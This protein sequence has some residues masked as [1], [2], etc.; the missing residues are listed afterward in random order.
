MRD[1]SSDPGGHTGVARSGQRL[2]PLAARLQERAAR[3]RPRRRVDQ[4][5]TVVEGRREVA[6]ARAVN[7]ISE[8][9]TEQ[10]EL[11]LWLT[12]AESGDLLWMSPA[13]TRLFGV[14]VESFYDDPAK[15]LDLVYPDD[16]HLLVEAL[17]SDRHTGGVHEFRIRLADGS[18]RWIRQRTFP[19]GGSDDEPRW[20]AGIAEDVTA[21][22]Q[23]GDQLQRTLHG[24]ATLVPSLQRSIE[25]KGNPGPVPSMALRLVDD[26]EVTGI[27]AR[28]GALTPRERQVHDLIV[29]GNSTK[30]IAATLGCSP[31]T[32]AVHRGR[33]LRKLG[34]R[35]ATELVRLSFTRVR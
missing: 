32:V 20:I 33:L 15:G 23:T 12:L 18:V 10:T 1:G 30:A 26:G 35:S 14:A 19:I 6:Q 31:K 13:A 27:G 3:R 7:G 8:L 34:V 2:R 24:L 4:R 28:L 9:F 22:R 5:L 11:V 16:R 17:R 25:A 21:E 29:H